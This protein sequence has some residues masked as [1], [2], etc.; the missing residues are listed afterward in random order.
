MVEEQKKSWRKTLGIG[1]LIGA[2][3][4]GYGAG[5]HHDEI[6]GNLE[7]RT[8]QVNALTLEKKIQYNVSG[9]EHKTYSEL[10]PY[11]LIIKKSFNIENESDVQN[12][13]NSIKEI[14]SYVQKKKLE[15]G[16]NNEEYDYIQRKFEPNLKD[17]FR[18]VLVNLKAKYPN[19]DQLKNFNIK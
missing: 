13:L 11:F 9:K 10:R 12:V 5:M 6:K 4:L 2:I 18:Y 16:K 19:N 8:I 3:G 7:E 14:L 17:Y 1:A 15:Y